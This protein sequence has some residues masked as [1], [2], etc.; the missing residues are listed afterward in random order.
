MIV[1]THRPSLLFVPLFTL[2]FLLRVA[3][4]QSAS[5]PSAKLYFLSLADGGRVESVNTDGSDLQI[6]S[7]G[8]ADGPDGIA[9]DLQSKKIYW[10][11][12]GKAR[13][14]DGSIQRIDLDGSNLT[15]IVQKGGTFTPKQLKLDAKHGKLYWSDREGMRIMRSNLDG[16][17]VETLVITGEGDDARK[18]AANW[19]VGIALDVARGKVYWSQKGSGGNGR[20]FRTNME[21]PKGQTATDRKDTEVLFDGLPEPI[22]IDLDLSH[23]TIY[24]SDRGDPPRG[25]TVNRAPMDPPKSFDPKHRPDQQI[26]VRGLKEGIGIALDPRGGHM[27]YTD[28]GGNVYSADLDG[29]NNMTILTGQGP[30]TGITWVDSVSVK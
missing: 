28:L 13:L 10:T 26:V 14:D 22:D 15:T 25:N 5:P 6:L 12:M 2:A 21:I 11:N 23:R 27:Y 29:S 30:L 9:V 18:D 19:C 4:A 7:S 3:T 8:K 24:W 20:I 1:M 17:N 16:S